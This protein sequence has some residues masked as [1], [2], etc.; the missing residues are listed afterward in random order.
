MM[1]M[2]RHSPLL[3]LGVVVLGC[4]NSRGLPPT[5]PVSGTVT[6][7]GKPLEM[8]RVIFFHPS[9]HGASAEL[10]PS[11]TFKLIAY[12]GKNNVA[13]ECFECDRPG[14]KKIRS[15]FMDENVSLIPNRYLNYSTSGLTFEVKPGTDNKADFA[16]TD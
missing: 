5:A 7:K 9:G 15:R 1:S 3:V 8:G 6:Y 4:G 13:V 2:L 14:S 10:G 11:G 12:Q 16:L